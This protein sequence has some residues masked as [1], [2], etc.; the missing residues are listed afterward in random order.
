M[1]TYWISMTPIRAIRLGPS[2]PLFKDSTET[3]LE[4]YIYQFLSR[5]FSRSIA[6]FGTFITLF[7]S[8][9]T[10]FI[11]WRGIV[12]QKWIFLKV[13]PEIFLVNPYLHKFTSKAFLGFFRLCWQD[14]PNGE[15]HTKNIPGLEPGV[16]QN[17][18]QLSETF[19]RDSWLLLF[20]LPPLESFHIERENLTTHNHLYSQ[21]HFHHSIMAQVHSLIIHFS[22]Q[23]LS[24]SPLQ[25]NHILLN[26]HSISTCR[27]Q[28]QLQ[29][30]LF[31]RSW[32]HSHSTHLSSYTFLI[33]FLGAVTKLNCF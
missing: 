23:I 32:W 24:W 27:L 18:F 11:G 20:F 22:P 31:L 2:T 26:K 12:H 15:F 6:L 13:Y 17:S 10:P 5:S 19:F 7:G 8:Q 4:I 25:A 28:S 29:L 1:N 30:Y 21:H 3:F 16:L 9:G 14:K 33:L